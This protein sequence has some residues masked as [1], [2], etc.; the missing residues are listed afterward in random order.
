MQISSLGQVDE[1][2]GHLSYWAASA[3][4]T[5]APAAQGSWHARPDLSML[6]TLDQG[7]ALSGLSRPALSQGHFNCIRKDKRVSPRP[8]SC[9]GQGCLGHHIEKERASQSVCRISQR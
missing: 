7:S 9:T 6:V 1:G 4:R 3:P 2:T 8:V 5:R